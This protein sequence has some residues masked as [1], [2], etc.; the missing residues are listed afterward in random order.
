MSPREQRILELDLI[1][2]LLSEAEFGRMVKERLLKTCRSIDD[3]YRGQR[4]QL[5]VIPK[6]CVPSI[7]DDLPPGAA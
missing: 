6:D 2:G 4:F 3:T 5:A 1:R 7:S